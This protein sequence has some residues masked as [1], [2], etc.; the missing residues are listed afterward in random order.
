MCF[1]PSYANPENERK[2]AEICR[3]TFDAPR[4]ARGVVS[5]SNHGFYITTSHEILPVWQE[6]ERFSTTLVSA[7]IGPIVSN[8]LLSLEQRLA[9]IG[10]K[11]SLLMVRADGLVQSATHSRRQAAALIHFRPAAGSSGGAGLC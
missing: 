4:Q 1:L 10:F 8:Y 11:G 3:E 5:P 6:Y 2:A 7:S 9:D